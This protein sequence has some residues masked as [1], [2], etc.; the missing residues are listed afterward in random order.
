MKFIL[1]FIAVISLASFSYAQTEKIKDVD[2]A[3]QR[4]LSKIQQV[5]HPGWNIQSEVLWGDESNKT[6][7]TIQTRMTDAKGK[8]KLSRSEFYLHFTDTFSIQQYLTSNTCM[9][10][11]IAKENQPLFKYTENDKVKYQSFLLIPVNDME[12]FRHVQ[13]A[14]KYLYFH[15]PEPKNEFTTKEQAYEWL[16]GKGSQNFSFNGKSYTIQIQLEAS[17]EQLSFMIAEAD[18]K[19]KSI[20]RKYDLYLKDFNDGNIQVDIKD[21]IPG[22]K[23]DRNDMKLRVIKY[24]ENDI[25]KSYV[26]Y[27]FLPVSDIKLAFDIRAALIYIKNYKPVIKEEKPTKVEEETKPKTEDKKDSKQKSGGK[28]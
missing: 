24:Y 27:M 16:M 22:V 20:R 1:S 11:I 17:T 18:M 15:I 7:V 26:S 4:L 13:R 14:L 2:D 3:K 12:G 9:V 5:S 25:L 10:K 21:N 6:Y 28:K 8:A 23:F 19:G